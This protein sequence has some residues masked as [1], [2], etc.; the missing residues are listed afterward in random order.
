MTHFNLQHTI[1]SLRRFLSVVILCITI[2]IVQ[3][4]STVLQIEL[5]PLLFT[6]HYGSSNSLFGSLMIVF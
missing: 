1:N 5:H 2:Q 4:A 6:V 3:D